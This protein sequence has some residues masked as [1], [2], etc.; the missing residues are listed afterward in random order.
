MD[1]TTPNIEGMNASASPRGVIYQHTVAFM[2]QYILTVVAGVL[3]QTIF[4]FDTSYPIS[5]NND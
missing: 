3:L 1:Y 2:E 5:V 4:Q